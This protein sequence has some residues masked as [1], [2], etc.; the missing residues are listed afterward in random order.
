MIKAFMYHDIRDVKDT[1]FKSRI[2]LKSF[3]RVDQFK[4]Q[5]S[6]IKKKYKIISIYDLPNID[7]NRDYAILTFDDGLKDHYRVASML[8]DEKIP[9]SFFIPVNA[10][11]NRKIIK[12]HKIQFILDSAEEKWVVRDIFNSLKAFGEEERGLWKTYSLSKWKNNWWSPEMVF[13]TNILRTHKKGSE[14][15]DLLFADLVTSDEASFCEDF[16]LTENNVSDL[17]SSNMQVG[18]HGYLS[19]SLTL[20]DQEND[21]AKSLNYVKKFHKNNLAFSYPNGSYDSSTLRIMEELGCKFAFTTK[22]IDVD[23]KASFLE[24][25]R[26]DAPQYLPL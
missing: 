9:A 26:Y 25:P 12:S 5:L 15:T 11:E 20:L 13:V 21:I 23:N 14:L 4:S 24:I 2:T 18:G 16:Y 3:L 8:S 22:Q 10:V 19:E 7:D 17:V 6:Y 1:L